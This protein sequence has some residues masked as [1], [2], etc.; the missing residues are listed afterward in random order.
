M[1]ADKLVEFENLRESKL[2]LKSPDICF[3]DIMYHR[4]NKLLKYLHDNNIW[5]DRFFVINQLIRYLNT[6][7]YLPAICFVYS[8]KQVEQY[9]NKITCC[10]FK[11]G[12]KIPSIIE[13]ECKQLLIGKV[14]NYKE[15]IN[16]PEYNQLIKLFQKGIAIHHAGMIQIF[17]EMTE[18][19]FEKGYIKLLFATETF[20]VGI[21]MPAKSVIFTALQKYNGHKFRFLEPYEYAQQSGRAGRRGQQ[22]KKGRVWHLINLFDLK[23]AI[24]NVTAY[25]KM[26]E[27]RPQPFASTFK[28]HYN[29]LLRLLSMKDYNITKFIEGSLMSNSIQHE[30]SQVVNE[31]KTLTVTLNSKKTKVLQTSIDALQRYGEIV[32]SNVKMSQKKRKKLQR[33]QTLLKQSSKTFLSDYNQLKSQKRIEVKLKNLQQNVDNIDNYIQREIDLHIKILVN[34]GFVAD[35]QLTSKGIIAANLQ[36]IHCLA[37]ADILEEHLFDNVCISEL[38]SVLSIFTS[39]S[40]KDADKVVNILHILAPE[41]VKTLVTKIQ[42]AY[43]KYYDIESVNKTGF[44]NDYN[45]HYNMCELIYQWCE[46]PDEFVCAKVFRDA[47]G[48]NISRGEFIKAIL[49]INNVAN[50]LIKVAEIQSNMALLDKMK[51]IPDVTLKYIATNQSLYL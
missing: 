42:S 18:H 19:L 38:A 14:A 23:N 26:L 4:I 37:M 48:F 5:I 28:I 41:N 33:E 49:K 43:H 9:A 35:N 6:R 11:D 47:L 50:E 36:E 51:K 10:L 44:A 8:R 13:K 27:G 45:I 32:L 39:V 46:A 24:P 15:Y 1:S 21:D 30:R 29:L 40:V 34:T 12:S 25:S 2:L 17:R 3:Q 22:D 20:A 7:D 16:L 31:I